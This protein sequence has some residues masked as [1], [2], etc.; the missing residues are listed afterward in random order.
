[1]IIGRVIGW[2][3]ALAAILVLLRD[4]FAWYMTGSFDPIALGRLWFDLSP[5]TLEL[6][7]PAI[8]RHIAAWLWEPVIV[9]IL[10]LPALVV[11][12]VPGILLLWSCGLTAAA[13]AR[14]RRSAG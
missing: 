13:R 8:Q 1:M 12:A 3:L 14:R 2:L 4:L 6:A 11:F 7:Q 10:R 5:N 9:T